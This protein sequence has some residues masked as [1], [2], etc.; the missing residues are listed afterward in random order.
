[1]KAGRELDALIAEKVMGLS[2]VRYQE[3]G[4]HNDLVYGENGIAG[5]ASLV[6]SYSSSIEDALEVTT[7]F[8]EFQMLKIYAPSQEQTT[9]LCSFHRGCECS[10]EILPH[11]ICL[12]ALKSFKITP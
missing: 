8:K 4:Y 7:K 11:A 2:K 6:P 3:Q 10:A 5:V 9:Y 1:M 12:A